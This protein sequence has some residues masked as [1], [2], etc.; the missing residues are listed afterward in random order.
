MYIVKLERARCSDSLEVDHY[1]E[2]EYE[3]LKENLLHYLIYQSLIPISPIVHSSP[4]RACS[5]SSEYIRW[6]HALAEG[7][8]YGSDAIRP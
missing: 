2:L 6:N 7:K 8:N 3:V 5:I 1:Y 4:V